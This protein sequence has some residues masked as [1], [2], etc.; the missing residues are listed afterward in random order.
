MESIKGSGEIKTT[1]STAVS[2]G[3]TPA[4]AAPAKAAAKPAAADSNVRTSGPVAFAPRTQPFQSLGEAA[5]FGRALA[6]IAAVDNPRAVAADSV[7]VWQRENNHTSQGQTRIVKLPGVTLSPAGVRAQWVH[8]TGITQLE[9]VDNQQ[10]FENGSKVTRDA[11]DQANLVADGVYTN[12]LHSQVGID[13]NKLWAAPRNNGVIRSKANSSTDL[14]AWYSPTANDLNYGTNNGRWHL[15]SDNDVTRHETGHSRGDK[16]N[17]DM[18]SGEGGAI[19][20]G[21]FGDFPASLMARNPFLSEDFGTALGQPGQ[22]LRNLDN[23][24]TLRQAGNEVHDRGE[25]YGGFG[26]RVTQQLG[27]RLGNFERACDVMLHV[28]LKTGFYF[29]SKSPS[30]KDFLD[31]VAKCMR[32]ALPGLVDAATVDFMIQAIKNEGVKRE[33]IKADWQEPPRQDADAKSTQLALGLAGNAAGCS[34]E[35][36]I[37]TIG[38]IWGTRKDCEITTVGELAWQNP[39]TKL[40]SQKLIMQL[41]AINPAD[42]KKYKVQDGF[43]SMVATDKDVT[44][45]DGSG[46]RIIENAGYTFDFTPIPGD[47]AELIKKA[48]EAIDK[49]IKSQ[50][51]NKHLKEHFS[52]NKARFFAESELEIEEVMYKGKINL[53]LTSPAGQFIYDHQS[54]K[55]EARRLMFVD[56]IPEKKQKA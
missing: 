48:R 54:D 29:T 4:K 51:E 28:A 39:E 25:A 30:P 2:S 35:D 21:Y 20:E 37:K 41:R 7:V 6:E 50:L 36:A 56:L 16:Q 47:R 18:F 46:R 45:F 40:Q 44:S 26:W 24:K 3:E 42:G 31:A 43:M 55:V 32:D 12:W 14:N 52:A 8:V 1:G 38:G 11:F 10:P 5:F 13:N 34:P 15:A 9:T 23:D 17:P 49:F 22:P 53:M 27:T 19:H 33:M